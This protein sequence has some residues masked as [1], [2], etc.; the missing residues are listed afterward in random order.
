MIGWVLV[1]YGL[2]VAPIALIVGIVQT[3]G[4]LILGAVI[5]GVISY[6][7][8]LSRKAKRAQAASAGGESQPGASPGNM[9]PPPG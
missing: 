3:D 2:I 4:Q 6:G 9:G 1:R 7:W 5:W 8:F